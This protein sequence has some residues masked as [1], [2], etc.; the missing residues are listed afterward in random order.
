[1]LGPAFKIANDQLACTVVCKRM[2]PSQDERLSEADA[3]GAD[4]ASDALTALPHCT[5]R[6]R[7]A[8]DDVPAIVPSG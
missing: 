7:Q 5:F 3:L 6:L 1:M 2:Q 4:R 8:H